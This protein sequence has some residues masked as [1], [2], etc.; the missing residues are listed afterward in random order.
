MQEVA[1]LDYTNLLNYSKNLNGSSI[2]TLDFQ[3]IMWAASQ[4]VEKTST[5]VSAEKSLKEI[6]PDLKY[7]VL[8]ASQFK[9]WNRLDFPSS[10]LY[11]DTI[12]EYTIK[13]LREWRP[14]TQTATGYEP[15]VQRDKE[16]IQKG[17]HVVMIHPTVQEKMDQ[18][19][20]Y[21]KKIVTKIQKYFEDDIRVNATID[22]DSVKSMSQLVTITENGEIGFH[23]T[24]CDGPSKQNNSSEEAGV[25]K[26]KEKQYPLNKLQNRAL[27]SRLLEAEKIS[28]YQ[29]EYDYNWVYGLYGLYGFNQKLKTEN[30]NNE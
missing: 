25:K 2:S 20:D 18:D 10:K 21:A 12:D 7:Q 8:D 13:E 9:Y 24:V 16:K 29:P 4:K 14:T 3:K 1:G 19:P 22:P 23:E 5:F 11:E 30:S 17:I 15:W 6:Y 27:A 26:D 28:I